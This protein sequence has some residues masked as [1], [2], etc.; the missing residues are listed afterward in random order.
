MLRSCSPTK[1]Y[2]VWIFYSSITQPP[3]PIRRSSKNYSSKTKG[4]FYFSPET[5][6]SYANFDLKT[7][8]ELTS[9]AKD[10]LNANKHTGVFVYACDETCACT[11]KD[12]S[13]NCGAIFKRI[14][15]FV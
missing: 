6:H 15:T 14:L 4:C 8:F 5:W 2:L 7:H 1:E 9:I 13:V 11:F 10:Y 3:Y 12:S